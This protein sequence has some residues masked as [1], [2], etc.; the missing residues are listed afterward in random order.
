MFKLGQQHVASC[1]IEKNKKLLY[2]KQIYGLVE[3]NAFT[4][5][6]N[7]FGFVGMATTFADTSRNTA[8]PKRKL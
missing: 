5:S 6:Y 3:D 7:E 8:F 1:G 4:V 2:C